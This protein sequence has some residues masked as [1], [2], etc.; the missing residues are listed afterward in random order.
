MPQHEIIKEES[1][2]DAEQ[3]PQGI[4]RPSP[5]HSEHTFVLNPNTVAG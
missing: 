2:E 3:P 5:L 1:P 4:Q